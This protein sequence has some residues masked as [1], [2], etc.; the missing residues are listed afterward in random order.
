[1]RIL[2]LTYARAMLIESP[3]PS[4]EPHK[5]C[6]ICPRLVETRHACRAQFPEWWNAPVPA[7]GD[8]GAWLAIVGL[9]PGKH[10]ANRTGRAFTGDAAGDMLWTTLAKFGLANDERVLNGVIILNAVKCLPPENKPSPEEIRNCRSYLAEAFA[11]LPNLRTIIA[12]GQIA[13]QSAVKAVGAKLPKHR[14]AHG[15]VHQMLDGR[16]IIDSY[17]CSRY[18]QN[19][20]RITVEMFEDVFER[21]IGI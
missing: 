8:A 14:F 18:N 10:G 6:A 17:H 1:V 2:W 21:A 13:H 20:G 4:A 3:I 7:L 12:L 16:M 19:T 11:A 9:A 5:D 15:A